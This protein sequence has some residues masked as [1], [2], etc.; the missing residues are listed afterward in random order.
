MKVKKETNGFGSISYSY[1]EE[2]GKSSPSILEINLTNGGCELNIVDEEHFRLKFH[3]DLFAHFCQEVVL[4]KFKNS[5]PCKMC[6]RYNPVSRFSM[7]DREAD[8]TVVN[9]V[10]GMFCDCCIE[11]LM[12]ESTDCP[13]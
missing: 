5:T 6:N 2:G 7:V 9:S 13:F 11:D 3:G 1:D 8:G 12:L 4:E 10:K